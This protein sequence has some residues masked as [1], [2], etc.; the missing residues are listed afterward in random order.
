MLVII[1]RIKLTN[2]KRISFCLNLQVRCFIHFYNKSIDYSI[3]SY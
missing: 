1:Y 2:K 3:F